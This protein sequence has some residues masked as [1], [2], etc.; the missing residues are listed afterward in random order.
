MSEETCERLVMN[1]LHIYKDYYPVLGGI[2]NHI[3]LLAEEQAR[4]GHEV[5]VLVTNTAR[6]TVVEERNGVRIV[7]A[8][9]LANVSSAPISL[10]FAWHLVRMRP[11]IAHLQ[12]PYPPGE[13]ANWLLGRS[14]RTVIS[15][16]SDIVR[17]QG[18]LRFYRPVM[19]RVLRA[20]DRLVASTPNYVATSPYL[21]HLKDKCSVIPLGIGVERFRHA[22]EEAV[23]DIRHRHGAPLLLFVG[24]LRYYKGLQYLIRAM[25]Q[26]PARLLI[27]GIGPTQAEWEGLVQELGLSEK[28]V[29]LGEVPDEQLPALY[30]AADVFDLPASHRSGAYGLVQIEAMASGTPVVCTELG[31]GTSWVN[32]NGKTGLVVPPCDPAAL[33]SAMSRLLDDDELREALGARAAVRAREEFSAAVMIDRVLALY[34]ELLAI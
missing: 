7:K 11:D 29:F 30:H 8:G 33:A 31:T 5:T 24:R 18:W 23:A 2:E 17:Q 25:K 32:Q 28:V 14:R 19:W 6:A 10:S 13:V 27:A 9:R 21:S 34:A 26:V 22:D 12:F 15:Y 3:K 20:A 1:I 16:Q 4:R